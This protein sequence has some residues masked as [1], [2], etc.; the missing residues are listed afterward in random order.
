MPRTA[1]SSSFSVGEAAANGCESA[2][3]SFCTV[4]ISPGR[5]PKVIR[6][7]TPDNLRPIYRRSR[8]HRRFTCRPGAGNKRRCHREATQKN[9][10]GSLSL[11]PFTPRISIFSASRDSLQNHP[12]LRKSVRLGGGSA[13]LVLRSK[14]PKCWKSN[15]Y[16]GSRRGRPA[17]CDLCVKINP[18]RPTKTT[19]MAP[20]RQIRSDLLHLG[21]SLIPIGPQPP[22]NPTLVY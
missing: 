16:I 10:Q 22:P 8:W 7:S 1:E 13:E 2:D 15:P 11:Q 9:E 21:I 4:S 6:L 3:P 5:M 12:A 20:A 17:L 19:P 18:S 14:H